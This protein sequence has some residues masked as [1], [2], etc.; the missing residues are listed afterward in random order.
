[1][2][3]ICR[4]KESENIACLETNRDRSKTRKSQYSSLFFPICKNILLLPHMPA[5]APVCACV[6]VSSL[7]QPDYRIPAQSFFRTLLHLEF[8]CMLI[9]SVLVFPSFLPHFFNAFSHAVCRIFTK[10]NRQPLQPPVLPNK[11]RYKFKSGCQAPRK[12]MAGIEPAIWVEPVRKITQIRQNRRHIS[13]KNLI[14]DIHVKI[15]H[16]QGYVACNTNRS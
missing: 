10:Q 5:P 2:G 13:C 4:T 16:T 12:A 15:P 3:I 14:Q 9:R 1:M 8:L 6:C 7:L 11:E